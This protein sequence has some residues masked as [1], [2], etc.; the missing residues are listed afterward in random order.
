MSSLKRFLKNTVIYGIAAV[1][2]RVINFFLVRLHTDALPAKGFAENTNFYIWAALFSVLLTFG[3]E[4]SFFRF[5]KNEEKKDALIS[6][7]FITLLIAT[8]LFVIL[9]FF[10]SNA[11]IHAFDFNENP[12]QLKLF[13]AIMAIDTLAMIPF[14]YLRASEKAMN[15]TVVKLINVGLIVVFN[16]FFLKFLPGMLTS[17]NIENNWWSTFLN[18]TSIVNFIYLA[19][20][21]GSL[22]SLLI[23][24]PILIKF[25]WTFDYSIFKRMFNYGWP[26]AV[27]GIA[28]IINENL[29]K[30]LIGKMLDKTIMGVYAACYKLAVFM[31]LYNMAFKLG[32]EPF[33]FNYAKNERAKEVY[34][35][36]L[37]YFVIVGCLVFVALVL[38]IDLI[39]LPFINNQEYWGAIAIVPVVLLANLF[40]G[41]YHNLSV[42]YKLTDKTRF[43]MYFSIF[44]AIIT[45]LINVLFIKKIGFMASA[46]ATLA[47]YAAMMVASYLI[48]KKHYP[49]PY[50][51][52]K[53][54]IYLASSIALA[55]ISF[56]F[57]RED[58]LISSLLLLIFTALI[59]IKERKTLS[60]Y[61][62]K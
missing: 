28:Y 31:N 6:T 41:I 51:V 10:F 7:S 48:G 1:L 14:A 59:F 53:I 2:P 44:G 54:L 40:L 24:T 36:I 45:I 22:A 12:L 18:Q 62:K 50:D 30:I 57:F 34:A 46:W 43:A 21:I 20:L 4:T 56:K 58:Y 16:L 13:V 17:T 52:P 49:V 42:W 35:I 37:N 61:L 9:S 25:K 33:F 5:Y 38:F 23:L 19:N 55:F 47:A 27:A 60:L 15:Y 39:K 26:I 32:A 11:L 8:I 3:L 29:D